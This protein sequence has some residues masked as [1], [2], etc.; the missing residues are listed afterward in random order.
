MNDVS[1][2]ILTGILIARQRV[3]KHIPATDEHA[4]MKGHPLLGIGPVNTHL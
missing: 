4:T 2:N 1:Y 3:G